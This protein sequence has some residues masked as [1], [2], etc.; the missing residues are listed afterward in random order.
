MNIA[1]SEGPGVLV[2]ED[3]RA[4]ARRI[5]DD[6]AAGG[7]LTWLGPCSKVGEALPLARQPRL[8][9]VLDDLPQQGR[10][11][12]DGRAALKELRPAAPVLVMTPYEDT[13]TVCQ[14]LRHG[15]GG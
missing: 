10:F 3:D 14:A 2:I 6:R 9:L 11:R 5:R 7:V 15:A 8:A 12:P 1:A 13:A 4:A